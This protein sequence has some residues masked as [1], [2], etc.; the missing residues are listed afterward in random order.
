MHRQL[1]LR[2]L[3]QTKKG[4]QLSRLNDTQMVNPRSL[5]GIED[6]KAN[7]E[8]VRYFTEYGCSTEQLM[9]SVRDLRAKRFFHL[10]PKEIKPLPIDQSMV[11]QQ[12]HKLDLQPQLREGVYQYKDQDL[13][14]RLTESLMRVGERPQS[15][16]Y[17]TYNT[18]NPYKKR[19]RL[20]LY[21][22]RGK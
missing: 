6:Q 19:R 3:Q 2:L 22:E 20:Y 8:Q 9:E 15:T 17:K 7:T 18:K 13:N 1:F 16:R 5:T 10:K 14:E 21:L 12:A 11:K 4:G